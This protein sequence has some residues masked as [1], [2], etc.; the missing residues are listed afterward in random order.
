MAKRA[1]A[2][3]AELEWIVYVIRGKRPPDRLGTVTATDSD[4]AI[5][6]ANETFGVTDAERQRRVIVRPTAQSDRSKS[7]G[8]K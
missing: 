1:A 2:K 8:T 5:A 4:T 6:K 3:S 7:N